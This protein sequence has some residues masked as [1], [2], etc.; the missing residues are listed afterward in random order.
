[1]KKQFK[2]DQL[3][4]FLAVAQQRNFTR[5]AQMLHLTQAAVSMQIRQLELDVEAPLFVRNSR[6][7]ALTPA[8]ETLRVYAERIQELHEQAWQALSCETYERSLRIGTPDAYAS[9]ILPAALR[10]FTSQFPDVR[11]EVVCLPT[12][13]LGRRLESGSLDLAVGT[14]CPQFPGPPIF[15][16]E[17]VWVGASSAANLAAQRPIPLALFEVGSAPRA[18]AVHALEATSIPYRC[19]YSSPDTMGVLACA[20]AGNAIAA[21]P[22]QSVSGRLLIMGCEDGLPDLAP[23]EV[24]IANG[25]TPNGPEKRALMDLLTAPSICQLGSMTS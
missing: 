21:V 3:R 19:V 14:C 17:L 11:V 8:G 4:T 20:R 24:T 15:S 13:E 2:S 10:A 18:H 22:R 16:E 1:M 6:L 12:L 23:L 25:R 9:V 7:L 5:A